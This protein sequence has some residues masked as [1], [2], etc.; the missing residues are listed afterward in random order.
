MTR[1]AAGASLLRIPSDSG[2]GGKRI[3]RSDDAARFADSTRSSADG[4]AGC[5][6]LRWP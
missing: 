3:L 1:S 4:E 5:Q 6:F 2:K